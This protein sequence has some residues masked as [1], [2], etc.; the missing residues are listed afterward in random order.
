MKNY[1]MYY[2]CMKWNSEISL[3]K[4]VCTK[5]IRG[6]IVCDKKSIKQVNVFNYLGCLVSFNVIMI[7]ERKYPCFKICG[8]HNY[9]YSKK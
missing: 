3:L 5:A 9:K 6:R 4:Y 2:V 1:V 7:W 8:W